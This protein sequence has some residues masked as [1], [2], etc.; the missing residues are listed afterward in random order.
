MSRLGK[1]DN[2]KVIQSQVTS[3]FRTSSFSNSGNCVAVARLTDGA[4]KVRDT[5]DISQ[6]ALT[7]TRDEWVAF[8]KGVRNN[9]FDVE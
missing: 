7:F 3:S 5:K 4:V 2:K 1:G 9:E 8:V 6:S